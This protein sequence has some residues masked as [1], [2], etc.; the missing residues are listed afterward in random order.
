M[1]AMAL[2]APGAFLWI[3]YQMQASATAPS[4]ASVAADIWPGILLALVVAFLTA[5]SYAQLAKIYP[6]AGFASCAYFA[7]KAFLDNNA[8][9][10][11][12]AA[13][14]SMARVAKL[15]TGW[16]AHLFYWVYPGVMVAMM[17]ILIGFIYT[18]FTGKTLSNP[19][20]VIIGTVFA[21]ITG[22]IAYRGITGSTLTNIWINV[23]QWVTLV[24]FSG[25]AIWYRV[26][27]PQHAT[28]WSF[29]G[30]LD[31]VKF[32][33]F[34]GVLVQST[35]AILILVGFE[36]CTSLAAE[37]KSPEKN[38]PK[39]II[40]ALIVQGLIA[41]L[42][43]YFATGTMIGST[44]TGTTGSGAT[45]ATVTAM[46]AAGNSSAPIGDLTKLI[47]NSLVPGLG[48]GLMI[49]MA[50]TVAIAIIGTTLSCMNTAVRISNG[51][52]E[53]REVPEFL[54]FMSGFS[55][56]HTAIWALVVVS[57][58]IAAIGVQSVVGLTGI[59]LASNFGTFVLYGLTCV[60]TIV[61][62][63]KRADFNVL[64]HAL[65]P[66]L[67]VL[68]NLVMLG[69]IIYLYA[70]G[71]ADSKNEAKIC[72]YIAGGWALLSFVYVIITSV[73][74]TYGIKM[75]SAMIRPEKVGILTE[76]LKDED[77][78]LGMTVTKV[79]G[80]GRQK[81]NVDEGVEP[82]NERISFIP[83][84]RVDIVVNDWEV[85]KVMEIMREVLNNGQLGD[86]KIFVL[87]AKEAMRI[88]TGEKG[89]YAV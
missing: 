45:A 20:L 86:G 27:N 17:A 1:N 61:A 84:V 59:T 7:E 47:G 44:L 65:I 70:I 79:K 26:H 3:T 78:L 56:P 40:I 23:I 55:T 50:L 62:F 67:G 36:S 46:A 82:I 34:S 54:S 88:R 2:I 6:Q 63:R 41:Y 73:Q 76:V 19:E 16:A 8:R 37:T 32:H 4:G 89:V 85:P 53:A 31:I 38:I 66:G 83:K 51:M 14:T 87:D 18:Q 33:S 68:V 22:Y 10:K 43:E 74:K 39:A 77:L 11:R 80:I 25:L 49:T 12:W 48:F 52:A 71:N 58:L 15:T 5:L 21:F 24:I 64:K 30:A 72:F 42:L 9:D 29:S 81:G 28:D 75:I 57:S 35:V 13:P 60:W 69:A